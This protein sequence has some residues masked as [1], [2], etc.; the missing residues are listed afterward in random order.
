MG[1]GGL[2]A[3][4]GRSPAVQYIVPGGKYEDFLAWER[5]DVVCQDAQFLYDHPGFVRPYEK[6]GVA[7]AVREGGRVKVEPRLI[8]LGGRGRSI[9]FP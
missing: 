8:P 9:T 6:D 5:L 4:P 1:W 2:R 3:A 7:A